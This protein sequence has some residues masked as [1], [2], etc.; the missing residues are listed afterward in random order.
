MTVE[1]KKSCIENRTVTLAV[2]LIQQ[3]SMIPKIHF[4][5]HDRPR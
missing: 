5:I 1:I 2:K 3:N 4:C